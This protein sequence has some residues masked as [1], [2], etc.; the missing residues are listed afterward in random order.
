MEKQIMDILNIGIGLLQAGKEGL[1]KA[2]TE[3]EKT[4]KIQDLKSSITTT[5]L[6]KKFKAK[7]QK[8]K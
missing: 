1:E 4:T 3:L 6:Q 7:C 5:K 2:K 8:A